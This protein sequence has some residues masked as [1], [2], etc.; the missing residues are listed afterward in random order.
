MA[1]NWI[2]TLQGRFGGRWWAHN[3]FCRGTKEQ[4]EGGSAHG[5]PRVAKGSQ[6]QP[7]AVNCKMWQRNAATVIVTTIL[8]RK[9]KDRSGY[10]S[11]SSESPHTWL[12]WNQLDVSNNGC[13][14]WANKWPRQTWSKAAVI[15]QYLNP[16]LLFPSKC[17]TKEYIFPFF[18]TTSHFFVLF[19]EMRTSKMG[20]SIFHFHFGP[21]RVGLRHGLKAKKKQKHKKSGCRLWSDRQLLPRTCERKEKERE[22]EKKSSEKLAPEKKRECWRRED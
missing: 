19:S 1:R 10:S 5:C 13:A 12:G 6:R 16:P 4:Y 15:G 17:H 21:V 14:S 8:L 7:K 18:F 11:L 22:R 3:L 20:I 2:K 9:T